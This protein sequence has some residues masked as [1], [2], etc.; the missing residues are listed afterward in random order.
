MVTV[1]KESGI[2]G[3][4]QEY[5]IAA[6][7]RIAGNKNIVFG[8]V[9]TDGTDGPGGF[10]YPG[11]P[12]CLAGAVVDGYTVEQARNAGIDLFEALKTH[13]T[14]EPMWKLKCGVDAESN[15]SALDLR[16]IYIGDGKE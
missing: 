2:G 11:A 6:A 12:Q 13:G 15:V 10:K 16:I 1:G 8:A 9:D 5:C 4:N 3:R 7:T 14:S